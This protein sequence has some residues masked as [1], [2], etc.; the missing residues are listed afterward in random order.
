LRAARLERTA[1][2]REKS[3][4][5]NARTKELFKEIDQNSWRSCCNF[6]VWSRPDAT[7]STNSIKDRWCRRRQVR[8]CFEELDVSSVWSTCSESSFHL[9]VVVSTI[10]MNRSPRFNID[11]QLQFTLTVRWNA[12]AASK[13]GLSY[14]SCILDVSWDKARLQDDYYIIMRKP[15]LFLRLSYKHWDCDESF[16][17]RR[18]SQTTK[19]FLMTQ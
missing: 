6:W 13:L 4:Q 9:E 5:R 18:R 11:A 15:W 7:T 17:A 8:G 12:S 1:E 16:T 19:F 10:P 14:R 3:K 2:N